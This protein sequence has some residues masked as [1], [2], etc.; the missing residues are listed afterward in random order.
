MVLLNKYGPRLT[1]SELADV[2]KIAPK[3]IQNRLSNGTLPIKM[4]TDSGRFCNTQDVAEYLN[5]F[6]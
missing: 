3:T 5:S 6:H 4:H 2:L 1:V